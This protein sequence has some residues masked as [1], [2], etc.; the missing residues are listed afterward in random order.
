MGGHYG[1]G[2]CVAH[3]GG[4]VLHMLGVL[5]IVCWWYCVLHVGDTVLHMLVLCNMCWGIV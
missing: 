4:I 5:C 2:Y 3:V 1:C